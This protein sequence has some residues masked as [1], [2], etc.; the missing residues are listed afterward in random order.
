MAKAAPGAGVLRIGAGNVYVANKTPA[1]AVSIA[2]SQRAHSWASNESTNV[3]DDWRKRT[4]YITYAAPAGFRDMRDAHDCVTMKR[5]VKGTHLRHVSFTQVCEDALPKKIAHDRVFSMLAYE[6][7]FLRKATDKAVPVVC[8][9]NIHPNPVNH[10]PART[11]GVTREFIES[12]VNLDKMIA[13]TKALGYIIVV[14]GDFNLSASRAK[15]RTYLTPY[16]VFKKHG[17]IVKMEGIDGVAYDRRLRLVDWD[18]IPK[19]ARTG[20]DHPWIVADFRR[21]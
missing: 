17:L 21:K 5:K 3:V 1:R 18:V 10:D 9:I 20:A 2:A 14:S 7:P 4:G 6:A 8:H 15:T 19:G 16:D 11:Q 13:F 12:M